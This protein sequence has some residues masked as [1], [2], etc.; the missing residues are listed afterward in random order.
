M[1]RYQDTVQ[2]IRHNGDGKQRYETMLYPI[3]EPQTS[4]IYFI[5]KKMDRMDLVA[6]QWY[7]DPRLWWVIQRANN[8]PGGTIQIP[9]GVRIRV[10][11]PLSSYDVATK[12]RERQF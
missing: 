2:K 1:Q 11:Y 5:S 10:P 12:L 3:F 4:D 7:G 8:L 9:P 6:Y